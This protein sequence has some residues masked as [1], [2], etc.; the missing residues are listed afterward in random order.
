MNPKIQGNVTLMFIRA[1]MSKNKTPYAMFSNG[2]KEFFVSLEEESDL[3]FFKGYKE[4]DT[5]SMDVVATVGSDR[6]KIVGVRD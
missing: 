3:D 1:G 5:I 2:R 4:D 6:M